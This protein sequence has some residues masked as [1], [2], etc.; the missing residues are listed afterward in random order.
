MARNLKNRDLVSDD[1]ENSVD[2]AFLE[3]TPP[4]AQDLYRDL[5][6]DVDL[7]CPISINKTEAPT[8]GINSSIGG[9]RSTTQGSH[10]EKTRHMGKDYWQN[11]AVGEQVENPESLEFRSSNSQ[12]ASG[13]KKRS[14][15]D[16]KD[17]SDL[18]MFCFFYLW[19]IEQKNDRCL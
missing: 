10:D 19:Y 6:A 18:S 7:N 14:K 5:V 8:S 2:P 4:D 15:K 17:K 9:L 11:R 1:I 16:K 3:Q 12:P 13:G